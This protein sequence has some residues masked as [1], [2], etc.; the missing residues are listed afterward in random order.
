MLRNECSRIGILRFFL[1]HARLHLY[2]RAQIK[3]D[4]FELDTMD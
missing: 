3:F 1:V 2:M 4:T